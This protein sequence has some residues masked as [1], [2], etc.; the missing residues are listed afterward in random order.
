MVHLKNSVMGLPLVKR[1]A[2]LGRA[3]VSTDHVGLS[4]VSTRTAVALAGSAG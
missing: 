4:Q 3:I 2:I 1:R